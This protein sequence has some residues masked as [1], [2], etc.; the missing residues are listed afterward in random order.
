[1][2]LV[3]GLGNPG[4]EYKNTRHNIGFN[5]IDKIC[6]DLKISPTYKKKYKGEFFKEK[7]FDKDIIFLKPMT[8]MNLSGESIKEFVN[9]YKIEEKNIIIIYDDI[10]T[11]LGYIRIRKQGSSGGHN[12]IKSILKYIKDFVRVRI[13]TGKPV[14]SGDLINFVLSGPKATEE[15]DLINEGITKGARAVLNILEKGTDIAMNECNKK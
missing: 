13:G 1:M 15:K 12:G 11:D 7:I 5:V 14:Y 4:N 2:Y 3:V 6:D 9:F 8:Y 10:D